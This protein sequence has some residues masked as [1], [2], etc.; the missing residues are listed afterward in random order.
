MNSF[1]VVTI[2]NGNYKVQAEFT[3]E[4]L[5]S[6][7]VAYFQQCA[8]L[9]NASDVERAVV[10]LVDANFITFMNYE[11]YIGHEVEPEPEV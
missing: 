11:E 8:A 10:R 1:A 2:I 6:A 5:N 3:E 9:W 7:R 4:Q